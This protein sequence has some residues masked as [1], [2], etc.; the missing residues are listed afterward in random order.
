MARGKRQS[1]PKQTATQAQ[2]SANVQ[3]IEELQQ[4]TEELLITFDESQEII[5]ESFVESLSEPSKQFSDTFIG[6]DISRNTDGNFLCVATG[7]D[8]P[9]RI[10][11]K[12]ECLPEVLRLIGEDILLRIARS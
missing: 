4:E 2:A 5:P 1:K 9:K 12:D 6:I 8:I 11:G 10:A 7:V 3:V